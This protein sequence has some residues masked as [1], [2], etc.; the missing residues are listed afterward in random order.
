M[1]EPAKILVID[2]E[3]SIRNLLRRVLGRENYEVWTSTNG[4][5]GIQALHRGPDLVILDL[6]LPDMN[7][8]VV[9]QKIRQHSTHENIP[10]LILTGQITEGL[11][12]R[13]LNGGADAYLAK[14]FDV[15]ELLAYVRALLRRRLASDPETITRGRIT[16]RVSEHQVVWNQSLIN[17]LAPKEFELLYQLVLHSPRVLGR[18]AL[19][20]KVWGVPFDQMHQRTVDVHIRRIRKKLGP[21]AASCLRTIPAIGYQWAEMSTTPTLTP[22][23]R[24]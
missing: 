10:I 5:E 2:D 16:I 21:R 18:D 14:P 24:P 1:T 11:R 7:G 12:T 20:Q 6:R 19:A 13:C 3:A 23:S 22:S 4:Q 17:R 8:E 9:C 15:E